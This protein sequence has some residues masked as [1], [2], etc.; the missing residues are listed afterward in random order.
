MIMDKK[1][2]L[3]FTFEG[4]KAPD[5]DD[6]ESA[7]W[8]EYSNNFNNLIEEIGHFLH[9][10]TTLYYNGLN[11]HGGDFTISISDSEDVSG[12]LEADMLGVN[13]HSHDTEI[14][15][16]FVNIHTVFVLEEKSSKLVTLTEK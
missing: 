13:I 14:A 9:G 3:E 2:T 15:S 7:E 5:T 4:A 10:A 16:M 12:G 8:Q 1:K 11:L 6:C